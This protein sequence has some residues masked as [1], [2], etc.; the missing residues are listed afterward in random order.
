MTTHISSNTLGITYQGGVFIATMRNG[1]IV[2]D[3]PQELIET[4]KQHEQTEQHK[5]FGDVA[6]WTFIRSDSASGYDAYLE[7][8]ATTGKVV[9][10]FAIGALMHMHVSQ[11]TKDAAEWI[12]QNAKM[13]V[14]TWV[15][16]G[17][18]LWYW[19]F[20]DAQEAVVFRLAVTL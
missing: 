8:K 14:R 13:Q 6:T 20:E 1:S 16:P 12:E 2:S 15:I 19:M 17:T 3:N 5:L 11:Q 10:V 18:D 9:N 4:I 7:Q